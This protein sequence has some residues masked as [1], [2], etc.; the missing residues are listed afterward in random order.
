M[1]ISLQS[2]VCLGTC[3]AISA[4]N[5][6]S[7]PVRWISFLA[8]GVLW[9]MHVGNTNLNA[10]KKGFNLGHFYATKDLPSNGF[11]K[12]WDEAKYQ[13][14]RK[15]AVTSLTNSMPG[16]VATAINL[17]ALGLI[18]QIVKLPCGLDPRLGTS[19]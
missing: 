6:Y 3:V 10:A 13:E 4:Y 17:L 18:S 5:A 19:F 11:V 14:V 16:P 9:G 12:G 15:N 1:R 2:K 8:G 7:N